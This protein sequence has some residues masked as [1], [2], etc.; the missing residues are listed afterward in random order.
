MSK[1]TG[2][3]RVKAEDITDK[4]VMQAFHEVAGDL[5]S[6]CRAAGEQERVHIGDLAD[7]IYNTICP[8]GSVDVAFKR[9]RDSIQKQLIRGRKQYV[10]L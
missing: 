6:C 10:S 3:T 8:I 5:A 9:I 4:D 7:T 2:N 1:A